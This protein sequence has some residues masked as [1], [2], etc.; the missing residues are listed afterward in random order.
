LAHIE[1]IDMKLRSALALTALLGVSSA[2]A[3]TQP[4]NSTPAPAAHASKEHS[5]KACNKQAD[6]KKLTGEART[7]F[8]KDCRA[9]KTESR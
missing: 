6:E 3:A 7:N 5:S 1:E 2:F 9:G 8:V 4:A